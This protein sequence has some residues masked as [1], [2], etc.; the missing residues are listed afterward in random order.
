MAPFKLHLLTHWNEKQTDSSPT[1]SLLRWAGAFSLVTALLGTSGGLAIAQTSFPSPSQSQSQSPAQPS[2]ASPPP[3]PQL[4]ESPRPLLRVG[5][6]GA[7]VADVQAMLTLLGFYQEA[8][9]G[10]FDE[11][12]AIAVRNFQ[13]W[14]GL[15][16]DGVVGESTWS[17]LLPT[18]ERANPTPAPTPPAED[19]TS[20]T[21]SGT[22][23]IS[24]A[25]PST[26]PP[27]TDDS[28]ES[29]ES[30][31][32]TN[33]EVGFPLLKRGMRGTAVAGLQER[34]RAIGVY[35]GPIDGVFGPQTETAVIAAQRQFDL[36]PDGVVGTATWTAILR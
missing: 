30:T 25:T 4:R 32:S 24:T 12:T 28:D 29:P 14:A 5:S 23:P 31:E 26:N 17:R 6:E 9:D 33:T 19:S 27:E 1:Q 7:A 16:A 35:G 2:Q 34:L 20:G 18:T 13:Q 8:V 22:R 11:D 21:D 15:V 3:S 10:R 36:V